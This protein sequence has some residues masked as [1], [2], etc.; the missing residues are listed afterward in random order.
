VWSTWTYP[1]CLQ[2]QLASLQAVPHALLRSHW[3]AV[4]LAPWVGVAQARTVSLQASC[5]AAQ[6]RVGCALQGLRALLFVDGRQA[7]NR[8]LLLCRF[9]CSDQGTRS[10]PEGVLCF[11]LQQR[12]LGVPDRLHN[13]RADQSVGKIC[14]NA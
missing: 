6:P 13:M 7:A 5:A 8:S 11:L 2:A 4:P 12:G 9:V 1:A 3:L 10:S 14:H